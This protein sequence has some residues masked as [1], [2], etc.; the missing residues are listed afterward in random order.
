MADSAQQCVQSGQLQQ[1]AALYTKLLEQVPEH[2]DALNFLGTQALNAGQFSRGVSLFQRALSVHPGDATLH[3]NLG[4]AYRAQGALDQAL[5]AFDSALHLKPE[6]PVALLHKSA[7][8]EQVGRHKEAIDGYLEALAQAGKLGLMARRDSLPAGLRQLIEHAITTVQQA[9]EEYLLQALA[10]LRAEH[11]TAALARVDRCL[12]M[13]LGRE[14]VPRGHPLQRC[15]FM[16]FPGIPAQAWFERS[17]FPWLAD[18]EEHT[19]EIR[20]ELIEVLRGDEGFRPFIE[21][22]REHPGSRYWEA[23]NY[24]PNWNAYF[25]YRDGRRFDDN[26][27]RCPVTSGLLDSLP[28]SRVAEHSPESFFS[29]LK[30]G[31]HIPPHTGVINTRLVVHLPLI[32]PP[33][34]GIRV[35]TETQGWKAGECIVFDDTFEHEAWNKSNRTRVVLIFDIWNPHLTDVEREAMRAVVEELGHF[36]QMHGQSEQAYESD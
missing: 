19:E 32:I 23:L 11:G 15:T 10:S 25:F 20:T 24:S 26:C 36:N 27:K 18:I 28:L 14:P 1:A 33:D 16:T 2:P 22:P 9:R 21:I 4:L 8:L 13:Y 31:A 35:G 6:Y 3:K 17:Q 29:V 34:C 7:V 5:S 30:P 12:Q